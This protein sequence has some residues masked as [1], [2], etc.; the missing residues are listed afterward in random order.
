[1]ARYKV[2]GPDGNSYVVNAPDSATQDQVLAYAKNIFSKPGSAALPQKP[3]MLQKAAQLGTL[4]FRGYRGL[5]VGAENL[6]MHPTQPGN[7]LNRAAEAT[8]TGFQ[9]QGFG[10]NIASI[11]GESAPLAPLGGALSAGGKIARLAKMASLGGG[12]S[13]LNQTAEEGKPTL[14]R[15][16]ASAAISAA[17]EAL[18]Q[19]IKGAF[20]YVAAKFTKTVPEAY[21]GLTTTFKQQFPGT[22]QAIQSASSNVVPALKKSFDTISDRL[23]SR[24]NYM[25]MMMTPKEALAEA[26]A[27]GGEPRTI[28]NIVREFKDIQRN[29][30]PI[31]TERVPSQLVGPRGEPLMKDVIKRGISKGEKLRRLDDMAIDINKQTGGSYTSDVLQSKKAI[32]RSAQKTG[33]TS[34]KILQKFKQ[35]WG[36]L[37]DIEDRLGTSLTDPN[38]S[39]AKLEQLVRRDIEGKMTPTDV[40]Q[41]EAV[42]DLEKTTGKKIIEPLRNQIR[43]SY[44]NTVLSDFVPKGMLGKILLMK[45]WPEGLASF[46]LGSPKA[47]GQVAQS[48]YNPAGPMTNAA[49]TLPPV[50][51]SETLRRRRSEPK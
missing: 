29:S 18:M 47:M 12:L 44:T 28:G 38:A 48:L 46:F 5:A 17:P 26:G 27:T 16:A 21:Q 45:Y 2:T 9:P 13:A 50:M 33:G 31:S 37:K 6:A 30:A 42:R 8:K 24:K 35:Q 3:S 36:K 4:P 34:Y 1:M 14:G 51:A 23:N 11:I 32:E 43:S 20:P 49:R 41:L 15:T 7:A 40:S 25:G 39:G 19:G 10:E 22:S